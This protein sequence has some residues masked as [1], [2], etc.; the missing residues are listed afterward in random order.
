[1]AFDYTGLA[2]TAA[3][4]I[5]QFGKA[6]VYIRST[7]VTSTSPAAGTVTLGTPVNTAVA[8]VEVGYNDQYQPGATIQATDRMFALSKLPT[9]KDELLIGSE[10]WEIVQVWP[11]QPG[12]T[13]LAAFVQIRR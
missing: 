11:K 13:F 12:D 1:M 2:A 10:Y 5:S 4:L 9:I 6:S 3:D 8:A 7:P